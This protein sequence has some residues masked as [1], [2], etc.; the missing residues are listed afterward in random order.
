[1][2]QG[3]H[4]GPLF[5]LVFIN[6]LGNEISSKYKLFADDLKIYRIINN[7][8]DIIELQS[9]INVVFNWCDRNNMTLNPNKCYF[10]KFSRKKNSNQYF[11][12]M[13][14][15]PLQEVDTIRDLGVMLDSSLNFRNHYDLIIN[16]ASKLS[17]FIVREMKIFKQP[18]LTITIYNSI[19][20]SILEY[21]STVWSPF[22]QVHSDRM[23]RVQKRFLYNLSYS[24]NKCRILT[25]YNSRLSH[26]KM[27]SLSA[28][29]K[30]LDVMFLFKLINGYIDSPE[31]LEKIRICVPRSGSRL[32]NRKT[33]VLPHSRT[34]LG[35][36]SPISRMLSL[37]N[38]TRDDIDLFAG[39]LASVRSK[40]RDLFI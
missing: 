24:D 11:Y 30:S 36:F 25:S 39:S 35:Q 21:C 15:S 13:D 28:R 31:L 19:V 20:R 18:I 5:F 9:D 22:Y 8:S 3:S 7:E 2:P 10:I 16:R 17:G 4:L 34:N 12:T 32:M 33:F 6:D 29:R 40:L 38:S 26:Y 27:K 37:A 1:M 23:E 14:N